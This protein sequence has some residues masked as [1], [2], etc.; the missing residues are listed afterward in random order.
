[1]QPPAPSPLTTL[2][3][4]TD[5]WFRR[6]NAAL[7]TQVP[8]HAGCSSCC[9]GLFSITRLDAR[10]VQEGFTRL[11][12]VER[13]RI[14]ARATQQ[15]RALEAAY[16]RLK[17]TTSIDD[18]SDKDIDQTV[19]MFHDS[20]CPAL[21]DNGLCALYAHRPLTCRS[22]GI[23]T[24][25]E[26]MVYGACE[27]QTFV[28]IVRLSASLAAEEQALA[29][30]EAAELAALPEVAKQGEEIFLPYAFIADRC[31]SDGSEKA[32]ALTDDSSSSRGLTDAGRPTHHSTR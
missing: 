31:E 19:S 7:F 10:R 24:Q 26:V 8:C 17:T 15:V 27:V 22:M 9:I 3:G 11:P 23:P 21:Q 28:P 12:A 1:M 4:K 29:K 32:Y 16:P 2:A 5:D 6:A 18:W 25:Q 30:Q 13:G 20:P 14:A